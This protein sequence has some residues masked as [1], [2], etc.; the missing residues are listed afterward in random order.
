MDWAHK[1]GSFIGLF[2]K[3]SHN[4]HQNLSNFSD[5]KN[6]AVNVGFDILESRRFLLGDNQ[7]VVLVKKI[8][9]FKNILD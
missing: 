8:I 7:L 4:E 1:I 3:R 2:A 9:L 6:V 5:L